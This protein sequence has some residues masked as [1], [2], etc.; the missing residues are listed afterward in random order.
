MRAQV[1]SGGVKAWRDP[2]PGDATPERRAELEAEGRGWTLEDA[3]AYALDGTLP[4][5][6]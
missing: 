6:P 2:E 1:D 3:L 5:G 4:E